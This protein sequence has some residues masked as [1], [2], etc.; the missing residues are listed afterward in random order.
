MDLV[1]ELKD[2]RF[3]LSLRGYDC[4]AVDAFLAK[5]RADITNVQE[6]N[7][8]A[9]ARIRELESAVQDGGGA[10]SETEG[11]LRRTLVLAQRL[12]D[13]TEAEAKKD[14]A[15]MHEAAVADAAQMRNAAENESRS[16][17]EEGKRELDNARDEAAGIRETVAEEAARLRAE[18]RV[19]SEKILA[20][21]ERRGMER[22]A[23][24]EQAAQVEAAAM[25]EPIRT[26]VGELE[27]ARAHVMADIAGLESHLEQQRVRVRTAVEALRVGMSG[28]IEDLE[29]VADDD[30]LLATQPAPAISGAGAADVAVAPDIEI[31]DRVAAQAP[32]APTADEVE[33]TVRSAPAAP[34]V[35]E[36]V[37][38]VEAAAPTTEAI[39]DPAEGVVADDVVNTDVVDAEVV[40]EAP[41]ADGEII[42]DDLGP[43]TEP[44]PV[45]DAAAFD[46]S[47]FVDD[48]ATAGAESVIDE[49]VVEADD[50]ESELIELDDEPSALFG[51]DFSADADAVSIEEEY[52][53][54]PAATEPVAALSDD[55]EAGGDEAS[56]PRFV[57]RFAE[58]L[59]AH[60]VANDQ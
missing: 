39:T 54:V 47:S 13:E 10:S 5:M 28:S 19:E 36:A 4:E 34:E 53:P 38:A 9:A 35:D 17:R 29:R 25:R 21:A 30:E 56:G 26:E 20:E 6:E 1:R 22:V 3:E 32:D 31:V 8:A 46:D 58:L 2:V 15:E 24:L 44:I 16:M 57:E 48:T 55:D 42:V 18:T 23:E 43:A 60:P 27:V 59:D 37:E 45:V 11:T 52:V 14:A 50:D 40:V 12:A 49:V 33:D 7:D 51:T 41:D